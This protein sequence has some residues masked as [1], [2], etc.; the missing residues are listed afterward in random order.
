M[1]P[2]G[3]RRLVENLSC[4]PAA[5]Y[6]FSTLAALS[7]SAAESNESNSTHLLPI[8]LAEAPRRLM[9]AAAILA[10]IWP[11]IPGLLGASTR[12]HPRSPV[13]A[14]PAAAAALACLA[15]E[16]PPR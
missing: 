1:A 4:R 9:P 16:M 3:R 8:A 13:L 6:F 5:D 15:P 14:R 12:R 7:R 10:A 11:A 2:L